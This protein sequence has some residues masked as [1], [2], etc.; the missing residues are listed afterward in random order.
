MES[1]VTGS[2]P[3]AER[4]LDS[5][6][7]IASY[8]QRD[9][10]TVQHWERREGLPVHRH[11]HGIRASVY[12]FPQELDQW[13]SERARRKVADVNEPEEA[14]GDA[15]Q[16]TS[17]PRGI[18][19]AWKWSIAVLITAIAG[20]AVW[21]VWRAAATPR[22]PGNGTL[23]VLPFLNLT[24]DSSQDYFS[25][26]ITDELTTLLASQLRLRVV[27]RT[28]AFQ[29]KGKAED[30]RS[31]GKQ[32]NAAMILEGSVRTLGEEQRIN[33]QLIRSS[34]GSHLWSHFYDTSRGDS[35]AVEEQIV[36]D[37]G[38]ALRLS[39][40]ASAPAR[41]ASPDQQAHNFLLLG[42]YYA[43]RLTPDS[44]WK[45]IGYYN[46][47][48]DG[49]PLYARAYLGLAQAY[50]VLGGNNQAVQSDVFPKAREA[51]ERA[52]QIDPGLSEAEEVLAH[53]QWIYDWNY[54]A[55]EAGY[56]KVLAANPNLAT[57]HLNYGILLMFQARFD[58][59]RHQF[60]EAQALDPLSPVC[61][62]FE[63][64]L[65]MYS[66]NYRESIRLS[67]E[68][69]RDN[70]NFPE[71]HD[72]L[73][74]TYLYSGNPAAAL[75]EFE[76][77]YELSGHDPGELTGFAAAYA[78]MGNREKALEFLKKS[79]DP[80]TASP[81]AYGYAVIFALLGDKEQTYF[82][83]QKAIDLRLPAVLKL[84]VDPAF[85]S[86]RSEPRFQQMLRVTGHIR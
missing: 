52:L 86:I 23:A 79:N 84:M 62:A 47:A 37:M 8:F 53:L 33:V 63:G 21:L 5:W 65:A 48:I 71:P 29:F 3:S 1:P 82:W 7:E 74:F 36:R 58:E 70:P 2:S 66:G 45:A 27:A 54:A 61:R 22:P 30:V 56:R 81:R 26:G 59:A 77:Y 67:E 12:A 60:A 55:A 42:Q 64:R 46:Q 32:L 6:K 39:F 72:A 10:R 17:R 38:G 68:A 19:R 14:P 50:L 49:Y 31:I 41:E 15:A 57:T 69:L 16:S 35:L 76:K 78:E 28:S 24:G 85:R 80:P 18:A 83:L 43:R 44:E 73:G 20:V 34:D 9:I 13:F 40:A 51:A 11:E 75:E 4:R 25:D